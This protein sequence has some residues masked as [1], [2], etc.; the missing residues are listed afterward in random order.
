MV[1]TVKVL[2]LKIQYFKLFLV[3]NYKV[4]IVL[5][6]Y[7][8]WLIISYLYYK[9]NDETSSSTRIIFKYDRWQQLNLLVTNIN[10]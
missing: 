8:T 2:I 1:M 5:I 6:V 3:P 10:T 7:C 4:W 9:G